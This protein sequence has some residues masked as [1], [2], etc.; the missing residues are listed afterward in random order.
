VDVLGQIECFVFRDIEWKGQ[1]QSLYSIKWW[2][3]WWKLNYEGIW[4]ELVM[5]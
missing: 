1:Y 5:V 4:K 3:D 2:C